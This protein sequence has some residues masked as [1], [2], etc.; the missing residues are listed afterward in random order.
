L[1]NQFAKIDKKKGA[2]PASKKTLKEEK[3]AQNSLP[4]PDYTS[5][6]KNDQDQLKPDKGKKFKKVL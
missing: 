3:I 5:V 1:A 6:K 4:T 2:T